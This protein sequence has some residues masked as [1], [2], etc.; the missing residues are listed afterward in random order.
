MGLISHVDFSRLVVVHWRVQ[1][2]SEAVSK[3]KG[4]EFRGKR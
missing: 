3:L 2:D 1:K 4:G